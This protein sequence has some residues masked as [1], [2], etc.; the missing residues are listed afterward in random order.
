ME[1]AKAEETVEERERSESRIRECELH[2]H[3]AQ[4]PCGKRIDMYFCNA[5]G[6]EEWLAR[7]T[8]DAGDLSF[9]PFSSLGPKYLEKARRVSNQVRWNVAGSW[10]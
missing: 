7:G 5:G 8:A 3:V 6:D 10:A 1:K 4:W 9:D 2:F